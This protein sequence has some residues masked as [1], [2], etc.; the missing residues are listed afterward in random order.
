MQIQ[1]N[2]ILLQ[3]CT[4]NFPF[5]DDRGKRRPRVLS[6]DLLVTK[7]NIQPLMGKLL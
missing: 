4:S 6:E 7:K 3:L 5:I 2:I 1:I